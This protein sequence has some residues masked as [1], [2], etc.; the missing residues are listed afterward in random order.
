MKTHYFI[1]AK[2]IALFLT[3]ICPFQLQAQSKAQKQLAMIEKLRKEYHEVKIIN[4]YLIEVIDINHTAVLVSDVDGTEYKVPCH[5][6]YDID[7]NEIISSQQGYTNFNLDQNT[8]C[9]K[10]SKKVGKETYY[11]VYNTSGDVVVPPGDYAFIKYVTDYYARGRYEVAMKVGDKYTYGYYSTKGAMLLPP[12]IYAKAYEY[13]QY[14]GFEVRSLDYKTGFVA[15]GGKVIVPT[16]YSW[17]TK[18]GGVA[19][20]AGDN[21]LYSTDGTV[22]VPKGVYDKIYYYGD[23]DDNA[24]KFARKNNILHFFKGG[25]WEK[26]ITH[27]Y[28]GNQKNLIMPYGGKVG[29]MDAKTGKVIFDLVDGSQIDWP[30][31]PNGDVLVYHFNLNCDTVAIVHYS[32][33]GK[34]LYTVGSPIAAKSDEELAKIKD[35]LK[36]EKETKST[37]ANNT[38][39]NNA[40]SS[41]TDTDINIPAT[42]KS[43]ADTYVFIVA[44]E[45]Y[46]QRSVP[47]AINDGKVFREYCEKTLGVPNNHIR[48]YSDAT[49]ANLLACVEQMKQASIA[50]SGQLSIIFY[51][52]GH[53]FPD[54]Q[55]KSAY[56]L[57][58]DGQTNLLR[59]CY[60]LNSLYKEL[61]ALKAKNITCFIDACFSGTTRE[62]EML[63]AGRGVAI[64]VKDDVPHGNVVVFTSATGDETAHQYKEKKHGLFTYYLLKKLKES[65]GNVTLGELGDYITTN[66]KRTSFDVNN[67]IQTPTVIPSA[68]MM[69]KWRN[70]KL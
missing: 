13:S 3:L 63:L 30:E 41:N 12:G 67:K 5:G 17:L 43:N 33:K 52:A 23:G 44:N 59:T 70:I 10:T 35:E 65:K 64:K 11:A 55:T 50:N 20:K 48:F 1:L 66:V 49:S 45:N 24:W 61:S 56:L 15:Y 51:Y 7:G 18:I 4:E 69:Q 34:L 68:T 22:L 8:G 28:Y 57:P 31:Y 36:K 6:V 39:N 32:P 26:T 42:G 38:S 25:I 14:N 37:V 2:T 21:T 60:S 40:T 46:P 19:I 47:F 9:L 62:N 27:Y 16:E 54:E 53:A 29:L 58:V